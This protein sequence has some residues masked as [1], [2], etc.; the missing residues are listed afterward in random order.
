[1]AASFK[2]VWY[3]LPDLPTKLAGSVMRS[4]FSNGHDC[5]LTK[6][7]APKLLW[8]IAGYSPIVASES[9]LAK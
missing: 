5:T 2:Q 1:L 3:P 6:S 9:T 7:D 4:D 8:S